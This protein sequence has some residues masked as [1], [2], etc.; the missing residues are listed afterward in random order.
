MAALGGEDGAIVS[1]HGGRKPMLSC[2]FV[3]GGD[4]I[5]GLGGLEGPGRHQQPGVIVED[6]EDLHVAAVGQGPVG[7]VGL[8]ALI[9]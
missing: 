8:P 7:R 6:V 1:E 3:E 9:G 5:G 4:H 2:S